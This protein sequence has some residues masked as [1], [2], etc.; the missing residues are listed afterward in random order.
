MLTESELN[1]RIDKGVEYLDRVRP[2]WADEIDLE[3]LHLVTGCQCVIGQLHG[4][5]S[6][7]CRSTDSVDGVAHGFSFSVWEI[8]AGLADWKVLDRL[9]IAR[10]RALQSK[11]ELPQTPAQQPVAAER[12]LAK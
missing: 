2:G 12:R 1:E 11:V 5:Y 4:D 10:I 8:L 7:W 6:K 3:H 9:W